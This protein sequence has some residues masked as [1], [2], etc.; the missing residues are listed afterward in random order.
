MAISFTSELKASS[1]DLT[2]PS[3]CRLVVALVAGTTN[4]TLGGVAM[5]QICSNGVSI[6]IK[7]R[8]T[9]GTVACVISQA[10]RFVYV[11]VTATVMDSEAN[12]HASGSLTINVDTVIDGLVV[13]IATCADGGT[14]AITG[15]TGDGGAMTYLDNYFRAHKTAADLSMACV[16]SAPEPPGG[17]TT[18]GA[19]ASIREKKFVSKSHWW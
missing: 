12:S 2:I 18:Y 11:N 4:P 8:P 14:G 5:S 16:V 3:S 15:I 9:T 1:G 17:Q 6:S 10:T 19:F 7:E 13:G